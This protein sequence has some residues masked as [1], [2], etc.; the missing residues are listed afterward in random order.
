MNTQTYLEQAMLVA[1]YSYSL[2]MLAL[3]KYNT[4]QTEGDWENIV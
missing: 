3:K 2:V 1:C 4:D